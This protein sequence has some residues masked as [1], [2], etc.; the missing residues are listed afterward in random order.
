M[1]FDWY[2]NFLGATMLTCLA[3]VI[4]ALSLFALEAICK[5][6]WESF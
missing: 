2:L 1:T 3:L 4:V 5:G 6:I